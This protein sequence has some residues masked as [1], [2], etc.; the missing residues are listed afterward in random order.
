MLPGV[1]DEPAD[2]WT[3]VVTDVELDGPWPGINSMRSFASVAIS[4]DGTEHGRFEAV[5]G[6]AGLPRFR[7]GSLNIHNQQGQFDHDGEPHR[8]R[9]Q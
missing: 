8:L 1:T 4:A 5:R 2:P 7:P 3:Y 9:F 6:N